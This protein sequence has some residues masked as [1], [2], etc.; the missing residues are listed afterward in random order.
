MDTGVPVYSLNTLKCVIHTY[1]KGAPNG[2]SEFELDT[3]FMTQYDRALGGGGVIKS[4]SAHAA[5]DAPIDEKKIAADSESASF[6]FF[7]EKE[8]P[9]IKSFA[10]AEGKGLAGFITNMSMDYGAST[11]ETAV[12]QEGP[13]PGQ[14][15]PI[16]VR[17]DMNFDVVHDIAPGLDAEGAMRAPLWPIGLPSGLNQRIDFNRDGRAIAGKPGDGEV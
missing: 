9:I 11:W 6:K 2:H 10:A 8:N 12:K 1:G 4:W 3:D 5:H 17:V 15:A 14:K 16:F 7:D 13:E